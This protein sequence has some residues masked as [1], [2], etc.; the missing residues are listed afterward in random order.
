MAAAPPG[1]S[2]IPSSSRFGQAAGRA[3]AAA[4]VAARV[5][6]NT[7]I[8]AEEMGLCMRC[9]PVG[10]FRGGNSGYRRRAGVSTSTAAGLAVPPLLIHGRIAYDPVSERYETV[11]TPHRSSR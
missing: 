3:C 5:E 9:S 11:F 4:G 2:L 1:A 8:S 7:A 6:M 10:A